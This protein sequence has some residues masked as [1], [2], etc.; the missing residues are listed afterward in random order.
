MTNGEAYGQVFPGGV[1]PTRAF[2]PISV[3]LL[4]YFPVA[5]VDPTNGFF[6][7]NSGKATVQNDKIGERVDF[8]DE[9]TGNW[10]FYYHYDNSLAF[11]P[12]SG[13][14]YFGAA[15]LCR[16]P[17]VRTTKGADVHRRTTPRISALQR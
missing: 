8:V 5:N 11:N 7:N 12:L 14:A 9:K 16:D 15:R 10:S 4:K 1:I 3:N 6:S 17:H 2:D 13:Q